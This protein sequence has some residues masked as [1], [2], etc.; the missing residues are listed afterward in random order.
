MKFSPNLA[1][2]DFACMEHLEYTIKGFKYIIKNN[3]EQGIFTDYYIDEIEN[4][5]KT[6]EKVFEDVWGE[7]I[8]EEI[9]YEEEQNETL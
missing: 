2:C 5:I 9:F 8:L 4:A 3:K 1:N 7:E 6:L